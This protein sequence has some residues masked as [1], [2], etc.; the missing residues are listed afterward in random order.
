M[1]AEMAWHAAL[2]QLQME[3]PKAAFHTW[4]K[5]TEFLSYDPDTGRFT[6]GVSNAFA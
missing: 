3:M 5:N 1:N 6:V 4:V 2:G